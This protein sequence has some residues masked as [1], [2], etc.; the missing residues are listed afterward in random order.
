[1]KEQIVFD[2]WIY[3]SETTVKQRKK[4]YFICFVPL[5]TLAII[6]ILGMFFSLYAIIPLVLAIFVN[7]VLLFEYWKVKNN[8]LI[9][10]KEAI[11]I[12]NRFN[13]T[14]KHLLDYKK[15][16]LE[17]KKS[18]KRGGGIW[19]KF[20]DK[21]GTLLLKYEDM[22]NSPTMYGGKLLPWGE[23]IKSLQIPIVDKNDIFNL[24]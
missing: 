1:M 21:K 23:A 9:I 15:C 17:I 20:Y 6:S 8:H 12:T 10:T 19:L 11:Y 7:I 3:R 16:S 14:K 13:V 5:W 18:A 4:D 2:D 24:W 22:L